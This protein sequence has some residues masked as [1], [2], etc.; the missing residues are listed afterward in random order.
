VFPPTPFEGLHIFPFSL[1]HSTFFQSFF[2]YL[3]MLIQIVDDS[4]N[5]R[6]AIKS[7]LVGLSAEFIESSDGE[8]AVKQ[9]LMRKPDIVIMDIRMERIDG[10]AAT[11]TILGLTPNAQVIIVTQYNDHELRNAARE[12]GA[13]GY[14]LK[15]DLSELLQ[16][17]APV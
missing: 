10:I 2:I 13:V 14:V 17:I 8:E 1:P 12:A 6:E 15:D 5:M 16:I 4:S 11:R 7:V 3:F 9:Y